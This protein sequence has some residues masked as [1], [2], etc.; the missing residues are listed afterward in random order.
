MKNFDVINN[1]FKNVFS[2][3]TT[4]GDANLELENKNLQRTTPHIANCRGLAV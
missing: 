4:K 1:N 3:L 2:Q